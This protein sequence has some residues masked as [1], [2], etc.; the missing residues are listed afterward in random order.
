MT[1]SKLIEM[2]KKHQ[3]EGEKEVWVIL[4]DSE[5]KVVR[6]TT[7][8]EVRARAEHIELVVKLESLPAED[9][10]P[11]ILVSKLTQENERL[12]RE[13]GVKFKTELVDPPT[14]LREEEI[15]ILK[16]DPVYYPKQ[17][18]LCGDDLVPQDLGPTCNRCQ[19]VALELD[20][21]LFRKD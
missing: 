9:E 19:I 18:D 17:C 16:R 11:N 5:G 4:E 7:K 2:L 13:L 14:F 21:S 8:L 10:D 3:E 12:K 15:E 6:M 1:S 20:R